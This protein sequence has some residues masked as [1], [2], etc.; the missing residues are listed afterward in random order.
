LRQ[1]VTRSRDGRRS[2]RLRRA[3]PSVFVVGS[4]EPRIRRHFHHGGHGAHRA[5]TL[6][7]AR[8]ERACFTPIHSN[9]ATTDYT[10]GTDKSCFSSLRFYPCSSVPSVVKKL[11]AFA[12]GFAAPGSPYPRV[13]RRFLG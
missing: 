3:R 1:R 12:S 9:R 10:D 11:V 6:Y 2:R 8:R 5:N 4:H 7:M 13:Q